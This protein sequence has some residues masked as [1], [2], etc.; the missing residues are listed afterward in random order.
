MTIQMSEVL[1][2]APPRVDEELRDILT[3]RGASSPLA[4]LILAVNAH[5]VEKESE[6]HALRAELTRQRAVAERLE[7]C[8]EEVMRLAAR[9]REVDPDFP[10]PMILA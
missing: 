4:A 1:R 3:R 9:L 2:R 8:R 10:Q 6:C 7:R 5:A